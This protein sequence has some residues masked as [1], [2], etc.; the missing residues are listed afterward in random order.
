MAFEIVLPEF[1]ISAVYSSIN[2]CYPVAAGFFFLTL[3]K[4]LNRIPRIDK[5]F[6]YPALFYFRIPGNP[7]RRSD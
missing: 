2:E 4:Q 5:V 7:G 6:D 3:I 1:F